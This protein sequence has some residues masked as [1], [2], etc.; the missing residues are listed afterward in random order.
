L[1]RRRFVTGDVSLRRRFV[2][3]AL[4]VDVLYGDVLSRRRFVEKTFGMCAINNKINKQSI[5]SVPRKSFLHFI[6]NNL[7][8]RAEKNNCI[9]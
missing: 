3:E 4:C 1:L 5:K 7:S 8:C 9:V 2:K 6:I